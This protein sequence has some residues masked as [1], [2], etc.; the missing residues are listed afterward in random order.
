MVSA[1]ALRL[2][3]PLFLFALVISHAKWRSSVSLQSAEPPALTSVMAF[4]YSNARTVKERKKR[5]RVAATC[6]G[7]VIDMFRLLGI[8]CPVGVLVSA[9]PSSACKCANWLV[10]LSE[11]PAVEAI[12]LLRRNI[13]SVQSRILSSVESEFNCSVHMLPESCEVQQFGV[14]E[15]LERLKVFAAVARVSRPVALPP[16]SSTTPSRSRGTFYYMAAGIGSGI[17]EIEQVLFLLR[18]CAC[19]WSLNQYQL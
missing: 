12:G 18:A 8:G 16:V 6:I 15:L 17:K 3:G 10:Q 13:L 19:N 2:A 4:V 11:L 5:L 9:F 1:V 7:I 14:G